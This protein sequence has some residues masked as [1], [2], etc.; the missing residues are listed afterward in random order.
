MATIPGALPL[1]ERIRLVIALT[2]VNSRR[3]R[4]NA[5]RCG[6][7]IELQRALDDEARAG[8]SPSQK[9][10]IGELR[11]RLAAADDE[12]RKIEAE[13]EWLEDALINLDEAVSNVSPGKFE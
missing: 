13:H 10:I 4:I 12:L 9:A 7:E 8:A 6:A 5:R 11:E 1:T 3:L 2:E